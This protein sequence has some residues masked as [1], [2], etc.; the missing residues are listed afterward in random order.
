[1]PSMRSSSSSTPTYIH[2]Y[3][4]AFTHSQS[5]C[6]YP[7]DTLT[8]TSISM[9]SSMHLQGVPLSDNVDY[10]LELQQNRRRPPRYECSIWFL[11]C[12]YVSQD[13]EEWK[14]HCQSHFRGEEPPR[15]VQCPLCDEFQ[16]TFEDGWTA[17][18]RRMEHVKVSH[19]DKGQVLR[20][21][22]P[23]FHL[24][25]HLWRKDLIDFQVLKELKEGD[26]YLTMAPSNFIDT[27]RWHKSN[28]RRSILRHIRY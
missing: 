18:D 6:S 1:M 26:Y 13:A 19:H 11:S 23:D 9:G 27:H 16:Y 2:Q 20:S 15:T 3:S 5:L 17:W 21:S 12:F 24:F 25:E 22:R 14:R 7:V 28:G 4:N 8:K 10:I